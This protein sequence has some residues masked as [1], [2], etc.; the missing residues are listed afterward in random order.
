MRRA[1]RL[2]GALLVGPVVITCL[3]AHKVLG[4][5]GP[6]YARF[7]S[8]LVLLLLCT[9]P[10]AVVNVAVAVLRVHH[11]L[12]PVA[13]VT[14]AGAVITIGGSWLLMPHMGILGAGWSALTSQLIVATTSIFLVRRSFR[15]ARTA[16]GGDEPI[17]SVV[18]GPS[19]ES[20]ADG[21]SVA[22]AL[23]GTSRFRKIRI[24]RS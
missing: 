1:A 17:A 19:A 10:D 23:A 8:L 22:L 16:S 9:F 11:R 18:D 20:V 2:I 4:I 13:V 14:V 5:F 21:T 6:D 24:G 3:L 7:S 15:G 12:V